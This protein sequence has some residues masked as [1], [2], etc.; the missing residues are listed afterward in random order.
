MPRL[1][2]LLELHGGLAVEV[3]QGS[4]EKSGDERDF[5]P[6]MDSLGAADLLVV[7]ARRRALPAEDMKRLKD[8]VARGKPVL[9]LRTAS[10]AFA[11][12]G[13][14]PG[15]EAW[16]QFDREVLGC[17]YSSY[18][19]GETRVTVA[20][21]AADHPVVVGL[22]GPYR[23]RE[24]LYRSAPLAPT[25]T[26]L[27][28]GRCVDGEGD[29][30]RYRT[31]PKEEPDQPVAWVNRVGESRVFYTCLGSARASFGESWYRRL[32][33]NAVFWALGRPAPTPAVD[34]AV[35]T[36]FFATPSGT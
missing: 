22:D 24:T 3:L 1:A 18:P 30:P 13:V 19:H 23:V 17:Q 33:V 28:W 4:T 8:Y 35:G 25:S 34:A 14:R 2:S 29:D 7:F 20:P 27:L 12:R 10:H 21:D 15:L 6:G 9:A 5:I 26:V 36:T 32:L 16:P 31:G 11:P